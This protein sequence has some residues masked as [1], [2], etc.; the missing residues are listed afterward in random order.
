MNGNGNSPSPVAIRLAI[1]SGTAEDLTR[2]PGNGQ[3][4]WWVKGDRTGFVDVPK[5]PGNAGTDLDVRLDPGAYTLG[6]GQN[7][8]IRFTVTGPARIVVDPRSRLVRTEAHPA[9]VRTPT[10]APVATADDVVHVFGVPSLAGQTWAI[11]NVSDAMAALGTAIARGEITNEDVSVGRAGVKRGRPGMPSIPPAAPLARVVA[12]VAQRTGLDV[13]VASFVDSPDMPADPPSDEIDP[14]DDPAIR[15]S[16]DRY[17]AGPHAPA[18]TGTRDVLDHSRIASETSGPRAGT[19]TYTAAEHTFTQAS[20]DRI[21]ADERHLLATTGLV[22]P[23]PVVELGG[24]INAIGRENLSR[25][26]QEW[27]ADPRTVDSCETL[28]AT[29][30]GENRIDVPM[31]R[32]CDV[33]M[34]TDGRI[35]ITGWSERIALEPSALRSLVSDHASVLPR[36]GALMDV[37][38]PDVRSIVWNAQVPKSLRTG[39][40]VLR[41]RDVGGIRSAFTSVSPTYRALDADRVADI[42]REALIAIPGGIEARGEVSYNPETTRTRIDAI[43]HADNVVNFA[44]GD[45]FKLGARVST[46]DDGGGAIK[47]CL[48]VWRNG[49]Y[50]LIVVTV[51][52][53]TVES[54]VH[55][56]DRRTMIGNLQR[57]IR[58]VMDAGKPFLTRWGYLRDRAIA[59]LVENPSANHEINARAVFAGLV[60][61]DPNDV[62]H[63]PTLIANAIPKGA[64]L[65]P[66]AIER[67]VLAESLFRSFSAEPGDTLADLVNAVTRLHRE[68]VPVPVIRQAEDVGGILTHAWGIAA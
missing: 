37:L 41:T 22:L 18:F 44:A 7:T 17:Q 57:G 48:A 64:N 10:S 33:A 67:D 53:A 19:F 62:A 59:D 27:A 52:K 21:R 24:T 50:N 68:P 54:I 13:S 40:M 25:S 42:V 23:P 32:A 38:T 4:N 47:V 31:G 30:K 12:S 51:T 61:T 15:D 58:K 8:R 29:I 49:C 35:R 66:V 28:I 55:K 63:L 60:G 2:C 16:W 34:E 56:G 26:H 46:A 6:T 1:L 39:A 14:F 65:D 43:F 36:A 5:R 9:A 11:A 45:V 20:A 3:R